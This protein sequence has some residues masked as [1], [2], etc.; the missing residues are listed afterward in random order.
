MVGGREESGTFVRNLN[1]MGRRCCVGVW[2]FSGLITGPS[3]R[4]VL[5]SGLCRILFEAS[6]MM[7]KGRF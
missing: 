2:F 7:R 4:A 1:Y 6:M 3:G 5:G